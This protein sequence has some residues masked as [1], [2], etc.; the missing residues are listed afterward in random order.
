M[1]ASRARI[2]TREADGPKENSD[3]D[4]SAQTDKFPNR[5]L[6]EKIMVTVR[7][8]SRKLNGAPLSAKQDKTK[9]F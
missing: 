7:A 8:M 4:S 2:E 1:F 9:Q 5:F 6:V 3:V